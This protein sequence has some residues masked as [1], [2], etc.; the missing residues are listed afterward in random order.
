M[1]I[2]KHS[3][4]DESKDLVKVLVGGGYGI[5]QLSTKQIIVPPVYDHI[6]KFKGEKA[7]VRKGPEVWY[8]SL[9]KGEAGEKTQFL[10]IDRF[11]NEYPATPG[12]QEEYSGIIEKG[13]RCPDCDGAGCGSCCGLGFIPPGGDFELD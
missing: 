4:L 11:G 9:F 10:E 1:L 7:L 3:Y 8:D 5:Y 6:H 13:D 2:L 12:L